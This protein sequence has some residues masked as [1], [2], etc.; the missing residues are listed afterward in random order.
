MVRPFTNHECGAYFGHEGSE[1]QIELKDRILNPSVY[2]DDPKVN[3]CKDQV[4]VVRCGCLRNIKTDSSA[5][6]SFK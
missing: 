1:R 4:L 5:K 6:F 2:R 3:R